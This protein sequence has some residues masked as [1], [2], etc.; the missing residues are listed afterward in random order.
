MVDKFDLSCTSFFQND[1]NRDDSFLCLLIN[2]N[3]HTIEAQ[4][5]VSSIEKASF[6]R[7]D[8]SSVGLLA[9]GS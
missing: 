6:Q 5:T 9:K 4:F 8:K 2:F 7:Y 3:V 1:K